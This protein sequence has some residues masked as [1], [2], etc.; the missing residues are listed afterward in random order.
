MGVANQ[1]GPKGAHAEMPRIIWTDP[2]S[3]GL[4]KAFLFLEKIDADVAEKAVA[5][6]VQGAK[7][8]EQFPNAG[9][10]AADLEPEHKELLIPFGA[11][12]YLLLYELEG[13]TAYI[14]AVKHQKEVGY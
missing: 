6:I 12:G 11:A 5:V 14:L 9:R 8:L 7:I 1:P 13:D 10:P 2:A 3:G 4:L